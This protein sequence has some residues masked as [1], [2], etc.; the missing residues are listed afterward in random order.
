MDYFRLLVKNLEILKSDRDGVLI[1]IIVL[2]EKNNRHLLAEFREDEED[3]G[4]LFKNYFSDLD[5]SLHDTVNIED[6]GNLFHLMCYIVNN[7]ILPDDEQLAFPEN[8]EGIDVNAL[9]EEKDDSFLRD[10]SDV[11]FDDIKKFLE[12]G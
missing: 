2:D 7:F 1:E 11:D 10:I 5:K 8:I 4:Y 3:D 9:P 12:D 6:F